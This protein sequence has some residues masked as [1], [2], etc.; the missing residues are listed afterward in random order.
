MSNNYQNHQQEAVALSQVAANLPPDVTHQTND[1]KPDLIQDVTQ[2][3]EQPDLTK[4]GGEGSR[5]HHQDRM[6]ERMQCHLGEPEKV[7][8]KYLLKHPHIYVLSSIAPFCYTDA[9]FHVFR[10]MKQQKTVPVIQLLKR[11]LL[12]AKDNILSMDCVL[13]L[14]TIIKLLTTQKY[15]SIPAKSSLT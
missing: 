10:T 7:Y 12:L 11:R 13:W 8:I 15:P 1:N 4:G 2:D 5:R 14:C 9:Y 3:R 6:Q